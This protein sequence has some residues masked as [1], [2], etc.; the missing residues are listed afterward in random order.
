MIAWYGRKDE[1]TGI[2]RN[3]SAGGE[4]PVGCIRS[5]ETCLKISNSKKGIPS[6]LKGKPKAPDHAAKLAKNNASRKG[7]KNPAISASKLGK[8]SKLKGRK[9][10]ALSVPRGPRPHKIVICPHCN[11]QGGVSNMVRYHLDNCKHKNN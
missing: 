11:K 4:G 5:E 10:P 3:R 8:P 2:L 7:Q 9:R 1:G 6:P